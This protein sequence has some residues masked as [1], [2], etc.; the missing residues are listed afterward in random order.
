MGGGAIPAIPKSSRQWYSELSSVVGIKFQRPRLTLIFYLNLF[1]LFIIWK[2]QS[3][4]AS[5]ESGY[6]FPHSE[7]TLLTSDFCTVV[8]CRKFTATYRI[9]NSTCFLDGDA[10]SL[11]QFLSG[12]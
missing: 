9:I 11:S 6:I 3:E 12:V 8:S 10:I 4:R 7:Y 1:T 5:H 2:I